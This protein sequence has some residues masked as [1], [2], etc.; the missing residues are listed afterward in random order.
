MKGNDSIW[1][2][3]LAQVKIINEDKI[4]WRQFKK[5]FQHKYLFEHYYDRK[6]QEFFELIFENMTMEEYEKIFLE[7]LRY[8]D[9]IKD[10]KENIQRF[11]S[12]LPTYYINK[13]QYDEPNNIEAVMR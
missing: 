3:E 7:L 4:T 11:L 5:Y 1:W 2:D 10:E 13:I 8:V 6:I 12:G 9:Y